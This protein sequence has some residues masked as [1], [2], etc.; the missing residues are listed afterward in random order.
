LLDGDF[1]L[2]APELIGPEIGNTIWKKVRRHELT[3]EEASEIVAAF[4]KI[5]VELHPS[6]VLL[7]SALELA[8]AL[9]RTVYDCLYLALA[10]AQ[11]CTLITADRKFHDAIAAG[12]LARHLQWI[13]GPLG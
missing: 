13:E 2:A 11:D 5:G 12:P 1:I 8:V 10:V 9:D 7:P 4:P 6:S 3:P